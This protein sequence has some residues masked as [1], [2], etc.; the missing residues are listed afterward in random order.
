[1]ATLSKRSFAGGEIAPALYA[2]VDLVKYAT[3]TRTLRNFYVLKHGGAASRAGTQFVAEVSDSTK[4]VRLIP[5]IFNNDQT[6]VLEFGDQYMRVI[7]EGAQQYELTQDITG[8]T[9]ANPAVVTYSGADSFANGDEVYISGVVGMTE[10]N[11][12]SYKVS[13]V[14]TGANTFELQ[15]M[16]GV[17]IDSSSFGAYSSGG[18][19][20]LVYEIAT[21]YLEAEVNDLKFVQSADIITIVHPNHPPAELART[22]DTSWTLSDISL[23]PDIARPTGFGVVKGAGTGSN[24]F[25]YKVTSVSEDGVESLSGLKGTPTAIS[26]ITQASPAVVTY[27][28]ADIWAN[29]DVVFINNVVGM[30]EVNNKEYRIDNVNTGANTFELKTTT[31][32]DVDSTGFTA[33]SSGGQLSQTTDKIT[34]ALDG[35]ASVP[36][37]VSWTSV[38][39]AQE[40]NI[41]RSNGDGS[42]GLIGVSTSTTYNDIGVTADTSISPTLFRDVFGSPGNYPSTVTYIQQRLGFANTDND[43]EKVWLSRTADFKNFTNRSPLQADDSFNFT[44][45]GRQVN[46]VRHMIDLNTLVFFTSGGEWVAKGDGAG[47]ITPTDINLKQQGYNGSSELAPITIGSNALYVQARGSIVRDLGFNFDV[48]GYTGN[49]LTIFATHLFRGYTLSDWT[50]SQVPDSIVWAARSDGTLLGLTYVRE[51]EV[52]AWH[53]HDFEGGTVEN[54]V[55]VPENNVDVLYLVIKRTINGRTTR[56]IE[57]MGSRQITEVD[58]VID[59]KGLD[60]YL[61]YDGRNT[62]STTMTLSGGTTWEYT[63]TITLTASTAFFDSNDVGNQIQL[64]DASGNLIKFTIDTYSSSTVVNGRPNKTVPVGLRSTAVTTWSKAVDEIAGLWHLEGKSVSVF[65]DRFV[66]A[67][68]NNDSYD[69][70]TVSNGKLVLARPYAVIHIGLPFTCDIETLDIDTSSGETLVDKKMNVQEVSLYVESSRGIWVGVREP[71]ETVNFLDGL[72]ELKVRSNEGYDD[73]V[74][75]K[76]GVVEV[77][78]NSEWNSNGRVFIRQTDPVPL[79][80]LAIAPSGFFPFRG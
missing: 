48:D 24:T 35:T 12:R 15:N 40:Y 54:V 32:I 73:P 2:R 9:Q 42:F 21:N 71:D 5:F 39:G 27:S 58:D 64:T 13:N 6:Y 72:N 43:T 3:G 47:T 23:N 53:R 38:D 45:A 1:M 46:E 41:Y 49:D 28:G 16:A 33:Y 69:T 50:Y 26:N 17:D 31:G 55:S 63:E 70:V 52:F 66:V 79:S 36:H 51:Q 60:S 59:F 14:N 8:I 78:V 74:S 29:N 11:G 44:L 19:C 68:P 76:T 37:V 75:L 61:S 62:G 18:D 56:Y 4:V 80:V 22:G 25:I 30:T 65:A 7:K 67:N 10:I 77:Q 20:S 57:R 34:S